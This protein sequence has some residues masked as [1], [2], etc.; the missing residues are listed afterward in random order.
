[1]PTTDVSAAPEIVR[2]FLEQY[3]DAWKGTDED[4]ILAYYADAVVIQLPTGTL[5]GKIAVRDKFVRPFIVGFPGNVHAI[6][7]LAHGTNL[8]AVEWSFEA[9][10]RGIFA[11]VQ[12]T[13]REIRVPGCSFYE[14][15]LGAGQIT[16]GRIYFDLSTLLRQIGAQG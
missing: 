8:V 3:F 12:A 13:G 7:T 1:M 6:R 15:D 16:A 2:A 4:R 11:N 10:H 14:Y 5:E 9:V